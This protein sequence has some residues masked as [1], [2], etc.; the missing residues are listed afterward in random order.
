MSCA[1]STGLSTLDCIDQAGGIETLYVTEVENKTGTPTISGNQITAMALASGKQFFEFKVEK[2]TAKFSSAQNKDA[3]GGYNAFTQTLTFPTNKMSYTK[4]ALLKLM[5]KNRLMFIAKL[6]TGDYILLGYTGGSLS[7]TTDS[8]D[9]L[10]SAN[11][12][13]ATFVSDETVDCYFIDSSVV[14]TLIVPA[15]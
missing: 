3:K 5:S 1:L 8:G 12:Y 10:A 2:G 7:F 9:A 11:A 14:A 13:N 4:S 6:N 15:S